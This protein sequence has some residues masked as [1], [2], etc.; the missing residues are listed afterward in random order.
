MKILYSWLK[1]FIELDLT[2][3]QLA[4]KLT[5]LGIEVASMQTTGADFEGVFVAQIT[6]IEGHPNSDHLHLVTLDL[7][8]GKTQRVVC[9]AP[10]VAVGQ[11][12]PLARVGARLGKEVLK[13]AVI[14]GVPSEGMICS[15]DEL[16][17]THTRAHGILV[18]DE[19]L[20]LG[21]DVAS[22]YGKADTLFDLEITSN[23]PDLLSHLG[24]ARELG[25]LLNKPVKLPEIKDIPG[26]GTSLE[27]DIQNPQAC[28]RYIGRII[29]GVKNVPSPDWLQQRLSAMG[30]NPKNALVDITN[31]VMFELGNPL[32]AFD[33]RLVEGGKI[34]VR[35]ATA[36]EKFT[37][38]D[39]RE[40][41]LDEACLMIADTKKAT[42]LAG[43][44]GG[45]NSGIQD[46]TTDIFIEAAH[47]DAPTINKTVKRFGL[48]SDSAQRFERGTD[49]NGALLAMRRAS[50]L[51]VQICGG[52]ASEIRDVYPTPYKNPT[53]KF[54]PAEI[55]KILGTQI[56]EERLKEIF[57]RLAQ[58]FNAEG[59]KWTF[60]APTH[61]RDL[62][63]KWD[64]AEEAAR[65]AGY[66]QIPVS[67]T[68][69]FVSF[70]DAPKGVELGRRFANALIGLGFCECKNIDFLGEKELKAFG[71]DPKNCIRIKNA[72]AQGWDY[73][74]PVLLPALLKNVESNLRFGNRNLA[75]FEATKTF[76][77]IKG[78]PVENYAV[79]G[80]LCGT[81][82]QDKFFGAPEKPVDF[83]LLKGIMQALLRDVEGVCF[84]A[85][86]AVPGYMHPKICMDI[87]L[88]G[89]AI[90]R[91]GKLH[92][93]TLKAFGIKTAD[94]WAF[95]FATKQ[96]E[97]S[98]SAQNF[99]PIAPVA[100]FPP[101]LRDLSVVVDKKITYAQIVSALEKT[102]LDVEMTY[103]LIDLYEGEH[104]PNGKKSITFSLAFSKPECTLKDAQTDAAFGRIVEQLKTQVGAEL[105]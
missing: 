37:I 79:A 17:L 82:E 85:A 60:V 15:S 32:H 84:T 68:K 56:S 63:H 25:A 9:G 102:P 58:E 34:I 13:P 10:N 71:Q 21:T 48:S 7:G 100:V 73:L 72:L 55:N 76:Q 80:V 20:P 33:L 53:V 67:S 26:Q 16:G 81:L 66:D 31:Y 35:N 57:A 28:T 94:V 45:L 50:E 101:S 2:P 49:V 93:L 4:Q 5:E 43:V 52:T 78:F 22:L 18:L 103:H 47:F 105:R 46:D 40:L 89:K 54:T 14:R 51:F 83:Y 23:R 69:A 39:G 61:R 88:G 38:L 77:A 19:Q 86:S 64:L 74:R 91:F 30:L 29:R 104:L 90:G 92:P 3:A 59:E 12:V 24:V 70:C 65:F 62:N 11:K 41:T 36:G 8:N 99:N 75:L 96:M 87:T 95:E 97:T 6:Q 98:F 42:A 1:D 44:M 27:V